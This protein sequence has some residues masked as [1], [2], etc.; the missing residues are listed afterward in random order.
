M[1]GD[2]SG[3]KL[4]PFADKLVLQEI[5]QKEGEKNKVIHMGRDVPA[6]VVAVG[7]GLPYGR[8]EYYSP[9]A[10]EGMVV[11]VP[12]KDWEEANYIMWDGKKLRVLHERQCIVGIVDG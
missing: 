11:I 7:P 4:K 9:Q 6:R 10:T 1:S 5:E 2:V 8:G 3:K 12:R